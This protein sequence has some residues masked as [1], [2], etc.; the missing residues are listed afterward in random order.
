MR[1]SPTPRVCFGLLCVFSILIAGCGSPS[2]QNLDSLTVTTT[3]S[4]LS[5]GG[6]AVLKAVAHLSDGTTQDVTAGTQWTLSNTSLASL[7]SST[8]TAK[9]AGV[10]TVQAAYVEA[11]P[12][13]SSPAAATVTPQTLNAS[14][15]VTI[16]A[17][18]T[19]TSSVPIITWNAPAAISYGTALS[20][21]QLSA[22]ANVPGTFVYTPAA[23]T[24]LKAGKQTLSTTFTPADTKTYSAAT[25]T[26]QL[27]VNQV[28]PTI[29]W[30]AP[31]AIAVGTALSAAQLDATANVPGT[32]MYNPAAGAVLAAGT[33]QLTAVFSPTDA[34]DYASATAHTSLVV[35]S[36]SSGTGG[37]PTSPTGPVGTAPTG[38]GGPTINLNSGMSQSTL[39]SSITAASSCSL[40]VFAAGTY[41]ISAPLTIPCAANLTV[42]GPPTAPA[43][44]ILSASF[45]RGSGDI[46][47][48]YGCTAGTTVEY[49]MFENTGGIYVSTSASKIIITHNQFTNLPGGTNQEFSTGVYFDGAEN[50]S[51][52]N[53]QVLS[54]T[55]VTWNNFG[56]ANSCLT[57]TDTMDSY[58]TDQ[59]G[60]CAGILIETTVNGL[61]I[62]NNTFYHLEEGTHLL[63]VNNS[64]SAAC[65]PPLGTM[66]SNVTAEFNDFS[67]IHR[68]PWEEQPQASQNVVFEYNTIHDFHNPFFG[69]FDISMAC[70]DTGAT[71]PGVITANNVL[72]ENVPTGPSPSYVGYGIEA[73]G[74][75]AQYNNNLVE[76]LNNAIGIAWGYGASP[77]EINNNYVC[78]PNWAQGN[79]FIADEGYGQTPPTRTGNVTSATCAAQTSAAPTIS[80]AAGAYSAPITV[81]LA[82]PGL[83]SGLGPLGN[84]S[85]YYTT[86]GSTPT[87]NS[88]LYT[89]PFSVNAGTTVQAIG[90][91]GSGANAKTYPA[92]YGFVP[93]GVVTASYSTNS[94]IKLPVAAGKST[95][96]AVTGAARAENG[97]VAAALESVTITPSQPAVAIGSNTQLKA[98]AAF[99]DGSVK[100]V[101]AEFAWQSSDARTITVNASGMLAGLATGQAAVSG[102]YQG[103]QVSVPAS[104]AIGEMDWSSPI[105]ITEGGTYSGNWQSTDAKT[106]A[107]TVATTAPVIIEN[108][109]IRSAGSLIKTAVAG[110]SLTVRNSVGVAQNAAVKGQPNGTFLE[111]TS[112][113]RLDVENNYIENA[114]GGVIVHGYGGN[115]DGQETIVIRSNRARNMNGLLSDGNQGYLPGEG[116]NRTQARFIQFDS[117]QSVPGIDVGWNEVINYAGHSLVQDNI[118]VYRSGG[119]PNQP[120]DIHDTYIQGAYPYKAAQDA[121]S[122]GGIKTDAKAGDDAQQAP[123][124]NSIHDNQ[125][126]G[127]V[128]YGIQFAAGHDN[129]AAN[130]RVVSSGLLADGSKIAAQRVGMA[131]GDATGAA[132]ASGS[133]YNNTMRD[134]LIGWACWQSSCAQEGYR[135]DQF[136]PAAPADYSTNSVIAAR[137]ITLDM[138]NNEYQV[139]VNKMATA[140]VTVGPSF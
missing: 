101:T 61:T 122:G 65:E 80:P 9:A 54:N 98:I 49:L 30:A 129:V 77:W 69:T 79:N 38:C 39:Q 33:Q 4:T 87:V 75:G 35:S 106:P 42:T 96:D 32:F 135:K 117:V 114:Q 70:C 138:E 62:E 34:T 10:L 27:T 131:N 63:C 12:A 108:A 107:V 5:V 47:N 58:T 18:G 124:F 102:S 81:T 25:A 105:V 140:G 37:S 31:P 120:L 11:T 56:D 104:S 123:A 86:D 127:T 125:V 29:T 17:A 95:D 48:I 1:S 88:T 50:P 20:S 82:D 133:M 3:P 45:A 28:T 97:A 53:A 93:S 115:R 44:A 116:S 76:G 66:T 111:V 94:A 119:T 91:W 132:V 90:M 21:T 71:S 100:D 74:N 24:V 113:V 103:R 59:G 85:I 126:V 15:Q 136:F 130:N 57:P 128:N 83:S 78:G 72:V 99:N 36:P 121:Y 109:H 134:N 92:G 52:P 139:W 43:T 23:G 41:N 64:Q 6:A 55:T 40:I 89:G 16:T 73:W 84:T 137:Q 110:T 46:F 2:S 51:N 19:G 7:S 60:L 68:I 118:D 112:P 13:G 67:N 22:T 8:L 14:T 26:V